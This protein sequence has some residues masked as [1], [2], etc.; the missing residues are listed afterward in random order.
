MLEFSK[1]S[2]KT[3][4]FKQNVLCN[5]C[6]KIF[7]NKYDLDSHIVSIHRGK[8]LNDIPV[9]MDQ[10]G[11]IVEDHINEEEKKVLEIQ[12]TISSHIS[13]VHEEEKFKNQDQNWTFNPTEEKKFKCSIC[14][15]VFGKESTVKRHIS[16]VH[17]YKCPFCSMKFGHRHELKRHFISHE[18]KGKLPFFSCHICSKVF[19]TKSDVSSHIS[20]VHEGEKLQNQDKHGSPEIFKC[21]I[22][23]KV[24]S[25]RYNLKEHFSSAHP[26]KIIYQQTLPIKKFQK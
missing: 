22:C 1:V 6:S 14:F 25:A 2:Q 18:G 23:S 19:Q 16:Q 26:K 13:N 9:L 12:E 15:K 11:K 4:E 7:Q 10:K 20:N 3:G 5:I 8:I 21:F 24:F 17:M